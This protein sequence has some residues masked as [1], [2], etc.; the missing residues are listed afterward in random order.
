MSKLMNPFLSIVVPVYNVENYIEK[1]LLSCLAQDIDKSKYEIIVVNDGSKDGSLSIIQNLSSGFS[2]I[3]VIT[4]ENQGL[5]VARNTGFQNSKGKYVWFIDSDDYIENN[6]LGRICSKLKNDLDILQIQY[7]WV[8]DSYKKKEFRP[9]IIEGIKTGKEVTLMGGLPNPVP[10]S[11]YRSDFLRKHKLEFVKGI[12]HEDSEFKPRAVYFADKITSLDGV[13]YN[14]LQRDH[15]NIMSSFSL[16]RA[17]DIIFVN[18]SL[19]NFSKNLD[20]AIQKEFNSKIGLN[21][22][23]LLT[24]LHSLSKLD[25]QIV[26]KLLEQNA[27]LFKC[28]KNAQDL[29]YR[30]EG[31]IFC[32]N[33][34]IG[35]MLYKLFS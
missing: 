28:M 26:Y 30:I 24:R 34:K 35:L 23:S 8:F 5:S 22:N 31:S 17:K 3:M 19:F 9:Y 13:V 2:N 4:Q 11:I 27:H 33:I 21:M 18:N 16:K 29:K 14:Y 32:K 15:G 12:Y 10:F 7:R 6:C 20:F 25:Q 1:C